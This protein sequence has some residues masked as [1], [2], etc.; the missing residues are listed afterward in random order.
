MELLRTYEERLS[1]SVSALHPASAGRIGV[2]HAVS[3]R[4]S[5]SRGW[6][7]VSFCFIPGFVAKTLDPSSLAPRFAGFAIPAQPNSRQSQWETVISCA[8]GQVVTWTALLRIVSDAS[9]SFLPQ[10][11][12]RRSYRI[13]LAPDAVVMG[14]PALGYGT[15]CLCPLSSVHSCCRSVSSLRRTLLSSWWEGEYVALSHILTVLLLRG[16]CPSVPRRLPPGLCGGS[17]GPGFT[18]ACWP[19]HIPAS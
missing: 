12:A 19:R 10:G 9:S 13:P 8:G 4:G 16:G 18:R 6:C 11:V 14:M 17:A 1:G 2:F 7:E 3:Y 15:V 5:H